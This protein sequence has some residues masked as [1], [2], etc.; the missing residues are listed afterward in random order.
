[1]FPPLD[2]KET[3]LTRFQGW[4]GCTSYFECVQMSGAERQPEHTVYNEMFC[5]LHGE[6]TLFLARL[7][8][9]RTL[10]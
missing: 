5:G 6:E 10:R 2:A 7:H 9:Q 3:M 4:M 8:A 1:M